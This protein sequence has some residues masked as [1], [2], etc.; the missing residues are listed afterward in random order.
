MLT[1]LLG[2]Y[3]KWRTPPLTLAIVSVVGSCGEMPTLS[4]HEP[5]RPDS[6]PPVSASPFLVEKDALALQFNLHLFHT[7]IDSVNIKNGP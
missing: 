7:R 2:N 3:T 5:G 4:Y 1:N 6:A